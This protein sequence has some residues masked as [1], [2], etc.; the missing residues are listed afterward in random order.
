VFPG[1]HE[2]DSHAFRRRVVLLGAGGLFLMLIGAAIVWRALEPRYLGKTT[3]EWFPRWVQ[4]GAVSSRIYPAA[5]KTN[6][7]PAFLPVLMRASQSRTDISEFLWKVASDTVPDDWLLRVGRPVRAEEVRSLAVQLMAR[8]ARQAD[9]AEALIGEFPRLG[10][11]EQLELLRDL[12]RFRIPPGPMTPLLDRLLGEPG[13]RI[14]VAAAS[15][16]SGSPELARSRAVRLLDVVTAASADTNLLAELFMPLSSVVYRSATWG[17][18]PREGV[19]LL[20][21][22]ATRDNPAMRVASRLTLARVDPDRHPIE[23]FFREELY[24]MSSAELDEVGRFFRFGLGGF[25]RGPVASNPEIQAW[26]LMVLQTSGPPAPAMVSTNGPERR[27]MLAL[28]A[29]ILRAMSQFSTPS[30]ELHDAAV[31]LLGEDDAPL[32]RAAADAL[33]RMGPVFPDAVPNL[34]A[35]IARGHAPLPLLRLLGRYQRVPDGLEPLL[36]ELAAGKIPAGW[37]SDPLIPGDR[38]RRSVQMEA[39]GGLQEAAKAL[40]GRTGSPGTAAPPR[41]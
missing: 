32:R 14:P 2:S 41:G 7:S 10:E 30:R 22:L 16:V 18:L 13:H 26:M 4:R 25:R 11:G 8:N 38:S 1:Q 5:T 19:A 24:G 15:I 28:K 20:E 12:G 40:L 36:T 31:Q 21:Q 29:E 33:E 35:A 9:F 37:K 23:R 17:G 39:R 3:D 27:R 34:G 6:E